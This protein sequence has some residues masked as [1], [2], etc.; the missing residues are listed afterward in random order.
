MMSPRL[1]RKR[2]RSDCQARRSKI[3][4]NSQLEIRNRPIFRIVEGTWFYFSG[5][6]P[7]S[8]ESTQPNCMPFAPSAWYV[9]S[10]LHP[11][12]LEYAHF[13]GIGQSGITHV[14][15][16]GARTNQVR[17]YLVRSKFSELCSGRYDTCTHESH[18]TQNRGSRS[19]Y[20]Q[21]YS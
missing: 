14:T 11:E 1:G 20:E 2:L 21:S 4:E 7:S 5:L 19:L 10:Q 8:F 17:A 9:V 12:G 13:Q 3:S 16:T 6:D 18:S 15:L